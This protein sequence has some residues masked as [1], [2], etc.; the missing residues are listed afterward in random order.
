MA[1]IIP[2]R[3]IRPPRNKVSLV[4]SR[5]YIDYSKKDFRKKLA[6]NPYTF[7]HVIT[8]TYG[9]KE[10]KKKS[11]SERYEAVRKKF[12]KFTRKGIFF[13]DDKPMFYI[14]RQVKQG[15]T[16]TGIIAGISVD[17][18]NKGNIKKHEHTL[19]NREKIFAE[20]LRATRINAEPVLLTFNHIPEIESFFEEIEKRRP[21]YEFSTTDK[22][23]HYLWLVED[24]E[25]IACIKRC[26][27]DVGHFYIADGHH[28]C[29][30]SALLAKQLH[31]ELGHK[32]PRPY[33]Y[34]MAFLL[35]DKQINILPFHRLVRSL[36][37][38]TPEAFV[39]QLNKAF[40]VERSPRKVHPS[41][42]LEFGMYLDFQ[43]YKLTLREG[44]YDPKN[45]VEQLD[46]YQLS[47]KILCPILDIT[48]IKTDRR[49]GFYGGDHPLSGMEQLVDKEKFAVGFVLYPVETGQLFDIADRQ[50]VMPPKSTW[51]EPKLR[52]GIT[53]YSIFDF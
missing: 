9:L 42:P 17:D 2:F 31:S 8:A 24:E 39:E 1:D 30:S 22:V 21:E 47:D 51:I 29:A 53:I 26:F 48:D 15:H 19:T 32:E 5:S 18:F 52:S 50:M 37:G 27:Q 25:E 10:K 38:Y 7:L 4:G 33:D 34:F 35:S 41:K 46:S 6:G 44:F 45:P 40:V 43:W 12:E 11:F 3:A 49:I 23:E 28:R 13:R 20:Y 16:Y 36:N 14:Y